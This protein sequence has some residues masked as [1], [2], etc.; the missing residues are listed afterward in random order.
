MNWGPLLLVRGWSPEILYICSMHVVNL[1]L[2]YRCNGSSLLLGR[3]FCW[4]FFITPWSTLG[5]A[6]KSELRH[7]KWAI[8]VFNCQGFAIEGV[9]AAHQIFW[10]PSK[11]S[12][13]P[14]WS[15]SAL[16]ELGK[17]IEGSTRPATFQ[18]LDGVL[19]WFSVIFLGGWMGHGVQFL[20]GKS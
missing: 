19:A 17:K 10:W 6:P 7:S 12:I 13:K 5:D 15:L 11:S 16:S 8:W 14:W 20:W 3:F 2:G 18:S 9:F 1:G 4:Q